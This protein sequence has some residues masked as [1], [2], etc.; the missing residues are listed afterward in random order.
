VPLIDY[1]IASNDAD[2]LRV[3]TGSGGPAALRFETFPAKGVDPAVALGTLESVMTERSY[4]EV[5]GASRQCHP[6]TDGEADALS[7]PSAAGTGRT[8]G[9]VRPGASSVRRTVAPAA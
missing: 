4:D 7:D 2:A 1:F 6:L 5:T 3:L 8:G 9:Y